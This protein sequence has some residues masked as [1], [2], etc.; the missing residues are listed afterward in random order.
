MRL[1]ATL[2]SALRCIGIHTTKCIRTICDAVFARFLLC[3]ASH[4]IC[5]RR[6][7]LKCQRAL[8]HCLLH[9]DRL[10]LP[11]L[12]LR[13]SPMRLPVSAQLII[14][15]PFPLH[16]PLTIFWSLIL[17]SF[18]P[19]KPLVQLAPFSK[20]GTLLPNADFL[21]TSAVNSCP[22]RVR[23]SKLPLRNAHL[24]RR[25]TYNLQFLTGLW[26]ASL[27]ATFPNRHA[28]SR[29]CASCNP[30]KGFGMCVSGATFA[31]T[32]ISRSA[33]SNAALLTK[34]ACETWLFFLNLIYLYNFQT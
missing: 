6:V 28:A 8:A 23:S 30:H 18:L 13:I 34:T 7:R 10:L 19:L 26:H 24:T 5:F 33:N 15:A 14:P 32:L 29:S 22:A 17:S 4:A 2:Y 20:T 12:Y 27:L 21:K 9:G 25:R 16:R 3:L 31:A 11:I 1:V